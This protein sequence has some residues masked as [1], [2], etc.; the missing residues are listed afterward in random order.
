M[1]AMLDFL[2]NWFP[3]SGS[4]A[5]LCLWIHWILRPMKSYYNNKWSTA[6]FPR[7]RMEFWA[8]ESASILSE[9]LCPMATSPALVKTGWSLAHDQLSFQTVSTC[10]FLRPRKGFCLMVKW[11]IAFLPCR[12]GSSIGTALL[13]RQRRDAQTNKNLCSALVYLKSRARKF[14]HSRKKRQ[15]LSECTG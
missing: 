11:V 12:I 1:N 5:S 14:L 13:R 15:S 7:K 6:R 3:L 9:L 2:W 10:I 4:R 8:G